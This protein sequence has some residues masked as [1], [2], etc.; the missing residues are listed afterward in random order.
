MNPRAQ[1]SISTAEEA[2]LRR[3]LAAAREY[4]GATSPNPP[5]GAAAL[6]RDG[7]LLGI[8][9]HQ[10]AGQGHAEARLLQKA[11]EEGWIDELHTMLVTLEPCNHVGRT[12]ACSD[13]ILAHPRI[14]RVIYGTRDPNPR[15][16]GSGAKKLQDAGLDVIAA[17]GALA[18]ECRKLLAPFAKWITTRRPWVTV[19]TAHRRDVT[20]FG[21]SMIPDSGQKTFTSPDSLQI[22]HALRKRADAIL[23]GSGT[24][25]ADRPELTVRHLPDH[26]N[27]SRWLLVMDRRARTPEDWIQAAKARGFLV[28]TQLHSLEEALDFAGLQGCLEV[29][30]EAGPT[31][32]QA[33]LSSSLWDEHVLI[34][35]AEREG[36]PDRVEVRFRVS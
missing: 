9:A 7:R 22:A 13:A 27:K 15:V 26:P 6:D 19:K 35:Q 5:V 16:D 21:E 28:N 10:R 11:R 17:T 3:A 31:L 33:I 20:G 14:R 30:V 24:I 29:L 18:D 34:S 32:S 4:R 8:A 23:T 1:T 36:G 2:A 25:I 12:P